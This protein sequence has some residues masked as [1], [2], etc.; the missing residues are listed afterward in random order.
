[1][2]ELAW[3]LYTSYFRSNNEWKAFIIKKL[4]IEL[5]VSTKKELQIAETPLLK[6]SKMLNLSF[7]IPE[8]LD[9]RTYL[10]YLSMIEFNWVEELFLFNKN[11]IKQKIR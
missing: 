1:M 6:C 3:S 2:F 4:G 10:K 5:F 7:G 8:R 11:I 9:I